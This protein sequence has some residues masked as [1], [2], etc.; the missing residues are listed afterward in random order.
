MTRKDTGQLPM[1]LLTWHTQMRYVDHSIDN[2]KRY[3]RYK[4]FQHMQYDQRRF[5]IDFY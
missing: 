5:F 1:E 4:K 2:I 3:R